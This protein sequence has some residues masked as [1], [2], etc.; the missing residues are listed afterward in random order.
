MDEL[1]SPTDPNLPTWRMC[2][3]LNI[4]SSKI[5][6]KTLSYML[7]SSDFCIV[8]R[9]SGYKELTLIQG[10]ARNLKKKSQD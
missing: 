4:S 8:R 3:V 6:F 1:L 2:F 5:A 9:I 10:N 7:V